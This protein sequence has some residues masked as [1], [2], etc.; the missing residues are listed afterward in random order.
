MLQ[1]LC[2]SLLS[3]MWFTISV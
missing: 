3:S 2:D 1:Y